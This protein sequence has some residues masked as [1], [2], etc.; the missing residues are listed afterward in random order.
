MLATVTPV[1][2]VGAYITVPVE[3]VNVPEIT[4]G[5]PLPF[6]VSVFEPFALKV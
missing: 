3:G 5:V 6:K 4:N 1:V 2:P